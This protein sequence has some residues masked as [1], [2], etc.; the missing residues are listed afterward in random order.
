MAKK[1]SAVAYVVLSDGSRYKITGEDG[2]YWI[3]GDTQFRK[4]AG[5]QIEE[6]KGKEVSDDADQ[7]G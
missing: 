1:K 5:Y 6:K 3:C 4:S 7:R 2:K